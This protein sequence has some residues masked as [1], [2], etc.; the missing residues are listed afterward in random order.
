ML[1]GIDE[2][3]LW[4][5]NTLSNQTEYGGLWEGAPERFHVVLT[6]PPFAARKARRR[7]TPSV[8]DRATRCCSRS[9]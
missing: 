6:N 8:Q 2:P 3:H 7:R 4:H 5:G 9:T 1:H